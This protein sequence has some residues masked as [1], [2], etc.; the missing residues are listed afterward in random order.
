MEYT[1]ADVD[2]VVNDAIVEDKATC[3]NCATIRLLQA[4]PHLLQHLVV[5]TFRAI[6]AG[7]H[8]PEPWK[9]ALM[10]L[11]PKS[12]LIGYLDAYRPIALG[13]QDMRMLMAPLMRRF[14]AVWRKEGWSCDWCYTRSLASSP[15]FHGANTA[16]TTP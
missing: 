3:S 16:T 4:F 6:L 11:L 12:T 15:H 2:K 8:P 14:T 10:W 13:Q 1:I 9:E 5:A 7:A